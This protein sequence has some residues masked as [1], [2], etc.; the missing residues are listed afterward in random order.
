LTFAKSKKLSLNT[1]GAYS[2]KFDW[3]P[4]RL[5]DTILRPKSA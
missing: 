2:N 4:V 1:V 5:P 3:K